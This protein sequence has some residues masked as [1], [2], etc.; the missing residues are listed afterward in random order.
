MIV[1]QLGI[2]LL[3]AP[4]LDAQESGVAICGINGR[5]SGSAIP[6]S[7]D[8]LGYVDERGGTNRHPVHRENIQDVMALA[9]A[10]DLFKENED[11]FVTELGLNHVIVDN[12][13]KNAFVYLSPFAKQ[14]SRNRI[15]PVMVVDD[16]WLDQ[17]ALK[18]GTSWA[19]TAILAHELGHI[20]GRHISRGRVSKETSRA[21]ELEADEFAGFALARMGSTLRQAQAAFYEIADPAN[22]SE[23][24]HPS[25]HRRL[26]AVERGWR[27]GT[28]ASR[29]Y[30]IS[31][32]SDR[33]K[34]VLIRY[35]PRGPYRNQAGKI[36]REK[37]YLEFRVDGEELRVV[38]PK[39][40]FTH[41]GNLDLQRIRVPLKKGI[42]KLEFRSGG[43]SWGSFEVKAGL[44]YS[45]LPE[46][47]SG[48]T[49]HR[50]RP[51]TRKDQQRMERQMQD[52]QQWS[53][54]LGQLMRGE[55]VPFSEEFLLDVEQRLKEAE[56]R[57]QEA[58]KRMDEFSEPQKKRF[59]EF[60]E[61]TEQMRR[62]LEKARRRG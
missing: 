37:E 24:T 40:E 58:K 32:S 15:W 41:L 34:D 25:R 51:F 14:F 7:V 3:L 54:M 13:E 55:D 18:Q 27:K 28:N 11:G 49:M 5:F 31:N 22:E 33:D 46:G 39:R 20:H 29:H 44:S 12:G 36:V 45:L 23:S 4:C 38:F 19:R 43:G 62:G 26:A 35:A 57:I 1:F 48:L 61:R 9:Q 21:M 30:V 59:Q 16:D 10:T 53:V 8:R 60:I 42:G 52:A 2:A 47:Q 6:T 50:D 17:I 56:S